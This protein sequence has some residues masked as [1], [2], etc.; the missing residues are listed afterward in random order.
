MP[1]AGRFGE[2]EQHVGQSTTRSIILH[3]ETFMSYSSSTH[4]GVT[5]EGIR[6]LGHIYLA[7]QTRFHSSNTLE[8]TTSDIE[9]KTQIMIVLLR[10]RAQKEIVCFQDKCIDINARCRNSTLKDVY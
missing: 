2:G 6:E 4:V 7:K 8:K 1:V 3:R 5:N 9:F 10:M